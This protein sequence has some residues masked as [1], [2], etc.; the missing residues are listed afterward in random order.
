MSIASRVVVL[1]LMPSE[2][3]FLHLV[4]RGIRGDL[5][6]T[7]TRPDEATWALSDPALGWF[8]LFPL[9]ALGIGATLFWV[10]TAIA[11]ASA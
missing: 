2:A 8:A 5:S 9:V 11:P 6:M 4:A 1:F 3:L 10:A 7:D